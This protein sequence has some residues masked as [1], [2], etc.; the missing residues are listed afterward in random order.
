MDTLKLVE[1]SQWKPWSSVSCFIEQFVA[2]VGCYIVNAG[3][4]R[5]ELTIMIFHQTRAQSKS[6]LRQN[7]F[8]IPTRVV[9]G[10]RNACF[11]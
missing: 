2:F 5:N 1:F 4:W 11:E 7:C 6:M 9:I 10:R 8:V 3:N